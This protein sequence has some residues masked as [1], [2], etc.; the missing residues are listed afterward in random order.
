MTNEMKLT[1]REY[2]VWFSDGNYDPE[3]VLVYAQS[4]NDALILAY[5]LR[6]RQRQIERDALPFE[7]K[8]SIDNPVKYTHK[9]YSMG[10]AII[11]HEGELIEVGLD[12]YR[13]PKGYGDEVIRAGLMLKRTMQVIK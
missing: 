12:D 1:K 10:S 5:E 6:R 8:T 9:T 4:Q 7:K 3:Y 2:K 13:L 11:Q